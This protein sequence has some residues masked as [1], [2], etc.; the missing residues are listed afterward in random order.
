MTLKNCIATT[1]HKKVYLEEGTAIKVFEDSYPKAEVLYEALNTA[2][3]EDCGINMPKVQEVT[4]IDGKWS[5]VMDYIEG[6]TLFDLMKKNPNKCDEYI[7]KMVNLQLDIHEKRV[8]LLNKLKDK[9]VRQIEEN[10]VIDS[11]RKYELL[12]RLDGMPNHV[13]LC[14]GDF[15][16]KN[17]IVTKDGEWYVIDWVHVASG[18]ASA[19][20]ARTYLLIALDSMEYA[21]KYLDLFCEESGTNKRYV[22]QWMP[23]VA[24]AQLTKKRPE[25][26]EL[27][28]KWVDVF[29]FQ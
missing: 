22:Q 14:H 5:I 19:D 1:E 26:R 2:R 15:G 27:L 24:A 12:T 10:D 25:E 23:I 4:K 3:V 7:E 18:N 11:A 16:P 28:L 8:P 20:A 17:I 21:D 9:I 29:D 6:D 13:K